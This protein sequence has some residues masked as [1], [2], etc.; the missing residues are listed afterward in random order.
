MLHSNKSFRLTLAALL[1][2]IG[3]IIPMV[4]PF[5][6][7]L[8]PASFTLASHVP[9][10]F[11]M[12]LSPSIALAVALGTG[13][14]F[15]FGGFPIVVSL[16]ALSHMVF[17]TIGSYYLKHHP[18]TLTSTTRRFIFNFLIGGLHAICEL[19]VVMAFYFGGNLAGNWDIITIFLL[20]GIATI[21]HSM[22]DFVISYWIYRSLPQ[23]IRKKIN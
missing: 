9:I 8:E 21:V 2:A 3:I 1:I 18:N 13:L 12:F 4:S 11:A 10:M 23:S 15:F 16:R 5:K 20:V 19:I 6:I 7:I 22:I 14:G 17:A